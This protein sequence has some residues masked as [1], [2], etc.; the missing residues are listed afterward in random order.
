MTRPLPQNVGSLTRDY[1]GGMRLTR[2]IPSR[3]LSPLQHRDHTPPPG[4]KQRM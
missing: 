3:D 2:F 1:R 4:T